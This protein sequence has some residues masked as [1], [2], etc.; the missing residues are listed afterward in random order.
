[1][2]GLR[3]RYLVPFSVVPLSPTNI[4]KVGRTLVSSYRAKDVADA[5]PSAVGLDVSDA[6]NIACTVCSREIDWDKRHTSILK[7]RDFVHIFDQIRPVYLSL[8]GYGETLLNKELPAMIAHA[9]KA[10]SR[11]NVVSN[12]TLLDETRARALLDAGLAKLKVSIDGADP[13]VYAKHRVGADLEK[14]LH[15]VE[16][17]LLM[18]DALRLPSPVVEIQFV[19]FR[20]NIDQVCKLI[21]LCH[22]RLPGVEPNL[23]VMF[24]YGKQA[25]F[26]ERSIPDHDVDA[27][28]ELGRA[29]VLATKYGFRRTLGSI[30][31]AI[32][33]LTRDLSDAPCY[34]PW[35]SCLISTDGEV[36]PCCYH[37]IRGV[38]V[39]NVLREPFAE[40][41]NGQRMRAFR[42]ALREKRCADK[43]CASCR[44]EDAPMERVFG[45]V[46]RVPGLGR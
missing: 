22:Q 40:I 15:N 5:Y 44:Y 3:G 17:L 31:A 10:G 36:Y 29:R 27:L 45:V 8:S 13:E 16:R 38:S 33:Q 46:D 28:A 43:V 14:V 18:R 26:V 9:T 42:H 12:G 41:W 6:C 2:S 19:L 35:Y 25:G 7:L 1:M 34:V 11:V 23:L 32:V 20:E 30:D 21:E 24:T 4:G 37:S 39:G